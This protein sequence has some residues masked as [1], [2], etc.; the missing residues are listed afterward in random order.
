MNDPGNQPLR[1]SAAIGCYFDVIT[2]DCSKSWVANQRHGGR[3]GGN[4]V[5]IRVGKEGR[6][7]LEVAGRGERGKCDGKREKFWVT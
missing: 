1:T 7:S 3:H 6:G 4:F 5:E 2:Y